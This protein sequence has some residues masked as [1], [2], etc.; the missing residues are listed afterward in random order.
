MADAGDSV[1]LGFII[2]FTEIHLFYEFLYLRIFS[3]YLSAKN[4]K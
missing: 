3:F 4:V 2:L 1:V